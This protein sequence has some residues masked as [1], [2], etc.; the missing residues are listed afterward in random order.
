MSTKDYYETKLNPVLR[1]L[2]V[3]AVAERPAD[4][5]AWLAARLREVLPPK[6]ANHE[7]DEEPSA[8]SAKIYELLRRIQTKQQ[9][10]LTTKDL[11]DVSGWLDEDSC[12]HIDSWLPEDPDSKEIDNA[13]CLA[14][15][16]GET[17][18]VRLL[19]DR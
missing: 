7:S 1:P 9:T 5:Q 14:S 4:F 2:L 8:F 12:A 15:R 16:L 18:L 11:T 10:K 6:M 3:Q 19:L 13:L 17:E